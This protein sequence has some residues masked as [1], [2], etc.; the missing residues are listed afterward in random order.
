VNGQSATFVYVDGTEG[1]INTQETETSLTGSVPFLT[2]SGGT[3]SQCG[4][5]EIKTF[6]GPGTFCVS[7]VTGCSSLDKVDWLV[8]AGGGAGGGEYG[9]GG[10]AGGYRESPGTSTGSY[11]VSPL[12]A[13]PAAAIEVTVQGYSIVTGAGAAGRP[14]CTP[15]APAMANGIPSSFSTYT[16]AGGGTGRWDNCAGKVGDGGSGGGGGGNSP[17]SPSQGLGNTPPTNPSQG[18]NGGEG[19]TAA[20]NYG[21]SGGG[22][23]LVVGANGTPTAGGNGGGGATSSINGTPT[24]RAGGGGAGI[25]AGPATAG[26]GGSGGGGAGSP[27]APVGVAGTVNTGGGGGGAS[28][29]SSVHSASGAGGSG[30]VI[31]R[32]KFQ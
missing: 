23:A 29:V 16:S 9:G 17:C 2:T 7:A 32:Y 5:Y 10:G 21:R 14:A 15:G 20:P 6:T 4:D 8:A 18:S 28:Y 25:Y 1:W 19:Q 30:V 11:T 22:G 3:P 24:A 26:T 31:L 13:A 12:G 27:G